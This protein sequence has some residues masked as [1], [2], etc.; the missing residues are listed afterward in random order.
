MCQLP[1]LNCPWSLYCPAGLCSEALSG[2]WSHAQMDAEVQRHEVT[3]P[4]YL[5]GRCQNRL[6]GSFS[7]R[8]VPLRDESFKVST[9]AGG[10]PT[11]GPETHSD[12]HPRPV[13]RAFSACSANSCK[14]S[15]MPKGGS[16][17]TASPTFPCT[18][19]ISASNR[20]SV[21]LP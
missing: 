15:I 16:L 3:H 6:R 14:L 19:W 21:H 2:S 8:P 20:A 17:E 1:P 13:Y 11:T 10:V 18:L 5:G 7:K 12:H 9:P 4:G